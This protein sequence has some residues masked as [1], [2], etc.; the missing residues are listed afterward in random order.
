MNSQIGRKV[1][2]GDSVYASIEAGMIKLTTENGYAPSNTIFLD[3]SVYSALVEYV[4]AIN[5]EIRET[6]DAAN[7]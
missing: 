7:H 2:L 3:R 1:Y 5:K 6:H 4:N